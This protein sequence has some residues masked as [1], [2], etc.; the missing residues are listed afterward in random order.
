VAGLVAAA[1]AVVAVGAVT[2]GLL[3]TTDLDAGGSALLC[4]GLVLTGLVFA[5][6]S[7]IASQ[8]SSAARSASAIGKAAVGAAVVLRA[9]GDVQGPR[10]TS[11][12]SW[13]SPFGWAQATAPYTL[14]RWWPL[15]VPVGAAV[16]T[17][18]VAFALVGR[19]DH[20]SG[21]VAERLGRARGTVGGVV[22]LTWRRQR[23]SILAWSI[24]I[25]LTG[26]FVGVL[27]Q[28]L[29]DFIETESQDVQQLFPAGENGAVASV[30]AVYVVFLA[31]MA[32]AY[33]ATA[34]GA[35]RSEEVA[36]RAAAVL[37]APVSRRRWLGAQVAL[38]GGVA[39]VTMLVTGVLMGAA[40]ARSLDDPGQLGDLLGAAAVTLPGVLVVLG[41]AVLLLGAAPRAFPVVWAYVAYV[42][43]IGVLGGVLPDGA[44][45]L[46]PFAYLPALPSEP[47]SWGP[48]AAVTAVGALLVVAGL[49]AFRRRDA[50]G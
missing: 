4:A 44:D 47:M 31:V 23:T 8:V 38:A 15:L 12:W 22:G 20:G 34:V 49:A 5:G 29:V 24:A 10:S 18:G 43:L 26:V 16:V 27:A 11:V 30:F 36:G 50:L 7:A 35:A 33:A 6:V 37:A 21:L 41:V 13:L 2:F 9:V 19:R 17:V 39:V 1:A 46:S 3:L 32:S 40:G 28:S 42:G 45:A 25:V 48:V 14:D